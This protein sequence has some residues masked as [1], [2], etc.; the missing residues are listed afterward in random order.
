MFLGTLVCS[1]ERCYAITR[2]VGWKGNQMKEK[3][4]KKQ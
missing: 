3:N 4:N 1:Y 2:K